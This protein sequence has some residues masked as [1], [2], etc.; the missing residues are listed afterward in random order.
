MLYIFRSENYKVI[1][2]KI[3]RERKI[4]LNVENY[5]VIGLNVDIKDLF[6]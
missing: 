3:N 4:I 5:N 1:K 2:V 6:I